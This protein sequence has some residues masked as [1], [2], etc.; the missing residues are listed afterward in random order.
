VKLRSS[1][2][3]VASRV[4]R[5]RSHTFT[6]VKNIMDDN[7]SETDESQVASDCS[8]SHTVSRLGLPVSDRLLLLA[9][10][11]IASALG[12]EVDWAFLL[13]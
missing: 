4:I 6:G 13:L 9:L 2:P 5:A 3:S 10:I 12:L 8:N 7:L 1:I 11:V